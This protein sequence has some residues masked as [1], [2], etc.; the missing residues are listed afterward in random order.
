MEKDLQQ[1][2]DQPRVCGAFVCD[3]SGEVVAS[4]DPAVLATVTMSALGREAARSFN[5]LAAAGLASYRLDYEYD[6]WRLLARDMG[7]GVLLVL[8]EP[9][10]DG[11]LVRMTSDVT[12]ARWKHDAGARKRLARRAGRRGELFATH[13]IDEASQQSWRLI[14]QP[15]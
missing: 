6:T 1:F 2:L 14:Q 12:I 3:D 15:A 5:A 8:C 11:A 9:G 10:V 7:E 13:Q 4:T